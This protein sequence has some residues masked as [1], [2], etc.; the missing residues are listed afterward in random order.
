[1][2]EEEK[3]AQSA[4]L[5]ELIRRG[6]PADLQEANR[7]MKVMAGFD[8]RHK[9]DYRAKAAEEVSKVQQKA[10]ILEEMLQSQ[11]PGAGIPEGDV[12]EEL[13]AALQSAH[14]KIQ[15][16]CE[17]ESDDPE[18]VHKLLE[19]N[20]SIHRTIERYKLVK[21]GDLDAASR[22][23]KGTLGTTT[24]VS[25]NA[26][27]ELS[28]IDFDPEEPSSNGNGNGEASA[29]RGNAL[30]DDL[31]G[32][33]LGNQE[34]APGGG[35][36]LGGSSSKSLTNEQLRY[37]GVNKILV[38]FPPISSGPS[39]PAASPQPSQQAPAGFKPNYDILASF[40]T[41]RPVSQ[42]STPVPG[43]SPQTRTAASPPQSADPFASLMSA[44]PRPGGSPFQAPPQVQPAAA[45][46]SLLDLMGDS[47]APPQQAA[48]KAPT[49]EDDDWNF[50]SSLPQSNALPMMN[51]VQVL[52]SQL[53]VDFA[54]RRVQ[55]A[56]RQIYIQA[57]F[58]NTTNQP[59]SDLHFQ[60]AV[61]KVT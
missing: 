34:P 24:G 59:I 15:K 60:V 16:M 48:A 55:T 2:E 7:L 1:M 49:T 23:P 20:D 19:I 43:A 58:S 31:L 51:K 46:S 5:Q 33:S 11:Q 52:N 53:R 21:K 17:E 61:E 9:T 8:N 35:I 47:A 29:Q 32:L 44:S 40:N 42:S 45:S 39:P 14:P 13:A 57:V 25:T 36:S 26:N 54:A 22:I 27:N 18:A 41:S 10:K 28:L 30:E 4:K 38:G 6:T 50:A 12:F 3:E 37:L 56:P